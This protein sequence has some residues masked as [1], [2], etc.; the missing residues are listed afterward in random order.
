MKVLVSFCNARPDAADPNLLLL[1]VASG[2]RTWI[3]IEGETGGVTGVAQDARYIYAACQANP[4]GIAIIEKSS[5]RTVA[6]RRLAEARDPHSLAVHAD[7]LWI[8][9]TGTDQILQYRLAAHPPQLV[10]EKV[11]WSPP[12]SAQR[13]DSHH[14]N[15]L[16]F[17]GRALYASGFGPRR[18]ERWSSAT[19]GYVFNVS[20]Q[21][22]EVQ[23]VYHP[24]SAFVRCGHVYC[25]ESSS[26]S[27]KRDGQ[28]ILRLESGYTRGL[29]L[30]GHRLLLGTS[31]GRRH[32]RSTG[33][34][35]NPADPGDLV[36]DCRLLVFERGLLRQQY[37]LVRSFDFL[38]GRRE[39]YDVVRFREPR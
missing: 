2:E 34:V 30:A 3:S 17:D 38:P 15:S 7:V 11:V 26:R 12:G 36:E 29:H 27:V 21:R 4:T 9:S 31:S 23:D 24:H 25:C 5:L 28:I 35:N 1:D 32:S 18:D 13:S 33:L 39:I 20:A 37:R 10:L 19:S 8:A 6:R 16:Y 22:A 14:L